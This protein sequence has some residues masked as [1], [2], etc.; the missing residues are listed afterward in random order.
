MDTSA[1]DEALLPLLRAGDEA[2]LEA[3]ARRHAG[4]L[5]KVARRLLA[6]ESDARLAVVDAFSCALDSLPA[7]GPSDACLAAW[8][9]RHLVQTAL[10]ALDR[11]APAKR[12]PG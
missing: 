5:L 9:Q 6:R 10:D 7:R 2:A 8:L 3:L 4:R 12:L 1:A 11:G